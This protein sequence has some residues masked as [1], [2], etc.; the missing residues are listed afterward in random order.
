MTHLWTAV[1][2]GWAASALLLFL[3]WLHQVRVKNATLVDVGWTVSLAGCGVLYAAIGPGEPVQRA[4]A[5]LLAAIWGLR[6]GWYL[7]RDRV[8]G[9]K[10]EDSRYQNLRAAWAPNANLQFA[11]FYQVQALAAVALSL[12]FAFIA[13]HPATALAPIQWVGIAVWTA[14]IILET[15]ADRQ[16]AAFRNDP[17]NKG[18]TCRSGLWRYSRHPNYFF[19][20]LVWV[21]LALVASPT[22]PYGPWVWIAPL[23]M[24]ILVTKVS[25]IPW[26]EMQSLKSRGEDFRRY[27]RETSAFV[28]W[29]PAVGEHRKPS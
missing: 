22:A 4:L 28:P 7:V 6:L 11:W 8:L 10:A 29:F 5:G 13:W 15:V 18:T 2:C 21:G 12:P 24:L 27:Q 16:L 19:E 25:G 17:A 3:L 1:A 23:V 20:W 9:H 26:A 14:S